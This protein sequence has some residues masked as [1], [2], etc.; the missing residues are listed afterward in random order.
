MVVTS[1]ILS[2][3]SVFIFCMIYYYIF[4]MGTVSFYEFAYLLSHNMGAGGSVTVV[5][6]TIIPCLLPFFIMTIV[7]VLL[8]IFVLKTNKNKLIFSII[9]FVI[10]LFCLVKTV[11]LDDYII[12]KS[13][14]TDIYEKYYVDTNS[15]EIKAPAE[16]RNL[17]IIYLESMESSLFSK[18]NGGTFDTSIIPELEELSLNNTS[19][20]NTDKQGGGYTLTLTSFTMSSL[21][22]STTGTPINIKLFDGYS[23][24]KPFMENIKSLGN[25]LSNDGYNLELMQGSEKEFG[26]L[27]L[28]AK[29]NGNYKVFDDNTAK[30]RGLVDKDYFVWWG[31]EDKKIIEFSKDE[32]ISL[33]KEEKPFAFILF[34][35]DTHFKD[36]FLDPSCKNDYKEHLAS[37][38]ACSSSM[39]GEYIKWIQEQDFYSNTT[40]ILLGDHQVMQDSFYKDHE[41]Y[42]RTNYNV[43]INSSKEPI[44]NKNREFSMFDMYPTILSSIGYEIEGNKLGFGVNLYSDEKTIIELLGREKFDKELKKSSNYY[45]KNIFV[46]NN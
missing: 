37:S 29:Y 11:H 7:V 19:F 34:T 28:Y 1:Y 4:V 41:D 20:S 40:I 31:I 39:I 14:S 42:I 36:G 13:K 6:D 27:D 43:I 33:S 15:V 23:D 8:Y 9:F 2:F 21:T 44:N 35:M 38:Y 3:L 16:K 25:V 18:E 24:K 12:N 22:A 30:E 46:K 5:L 32:L 26:A 17:I 45:N 10:S